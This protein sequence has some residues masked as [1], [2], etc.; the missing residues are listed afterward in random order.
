MKNPSQSFSSYYMQHKLFFAKLRPQFLSQSLRSLLPLNRRNKK[1]ICGFK[2]FSC[3]ISLLY[4]AQL[5]RTDRRVSKFSP[6]TGLMKKLQF[7]EN[8]KEQKLEI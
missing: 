6:L 5:H 3:I 7:C 4:C 2:V 8:L 1:K